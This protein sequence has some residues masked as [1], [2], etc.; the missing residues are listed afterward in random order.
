MTPIE[1]IPDS[2]TSSPD[3]A[4]GYSAN[5]GPEPAKFWRE[6]H[7]AR[8]LLCER[9][10]PAETVLHGAWNKLRSWNTR[11]DEGVQSVGLTLNIYAARLR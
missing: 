4:G 6:P 2:A 9:A 3:H 10:V 8:G 1:H 5:L 7:S 11:A